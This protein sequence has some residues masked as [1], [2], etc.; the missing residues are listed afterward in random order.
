MLE[1]QL[2]RVICDYAKKKGFLV[3][4]F[5]SEAR[6][7]VPD[8]LFISPDGVVF[9]V[10]MKAPGKKPTEAQGREIARLNNQNVACFVCDDVDHGKFI[11]DMV[12]YGVD[13]RSIA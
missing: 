9:F 10:E 11:V 3:Y 6:R 5:T 13:P 12:A 7:S 4:K 1:K 2:E 8:R